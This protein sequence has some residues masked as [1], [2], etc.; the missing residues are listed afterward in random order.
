MRDDASRRQVLAS[1]P[2]ASTWLMANAGSGKTRVLTDRV[3]RLLLQDVEPQ[4]ILCLTYTK[5]AASEMQNRLFKTLGEWAMKPD[6]ALRQALA[7][8]G[9]EQMDS[10]HLARARRLFARAIEA[11]GGL[12]IQTIHSFC[13]TLLRRFP[14]EA[15]VSP[16]FGELD[17]RSARLLR[18]EILEEMADGLGS[19]AVAEIAREFSGNDFMGLIEQIVGKRELFRQHRDDSQAIDFATAERDLTER[20]LWG[21][22]AWFGD[23]LAV[24]AQGSANDVKAHDKLSTIALDG[25]NHETLGVLEDT[26]LFKSGAKATLAKIGSFPTGPSQGKL[27]D[28]LPKLNDLMLRVEAAREQRLTMQAARK[29]AVLTRFAHAF[30]PRYDDGSRRSGPAC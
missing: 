14:L 26:L 8:L 23:L 3:A 22:G 1:K 10:G 6:A 4:Q 25:T 29:T 19:D 9:E 24:L 13:A 16:R 12:R 28:A 21:V 15:G 30:L 11:P 18:Q 27:G 5:S 17:D 2:D 20:L 7:D